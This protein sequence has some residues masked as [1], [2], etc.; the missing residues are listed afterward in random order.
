VLE[1]QEY[2]LQLLIVAQ[3]PPVALEGLEV[4][5]P[6]QVELLVCKNQ[7]V[8]IARVIVHNEQI[9]NLSLRVLTQ[10]LDHRIDLALG[11]RRPL[12]LYLFSATTCL[13]HLIVNLGW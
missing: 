4:H 12:N 11:A 5:L 8:P 9:L 6:Y 13:G 10:G 3:T 1:I 2:L 7:L